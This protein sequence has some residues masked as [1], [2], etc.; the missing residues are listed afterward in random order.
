MKKKQEQKPQAQTT[1]SPLLLQR[2]YGKLRC[3]GEDRHLESDARIDESIQ[4]YA[5]S[6]QDR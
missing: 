6:L 1:D 2:E 5:E 4:S 3:T